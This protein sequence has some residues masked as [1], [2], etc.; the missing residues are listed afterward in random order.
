MEF[1]NNNNNNGHS[2][3]PENTRTLKDYINLVRNNL[4]PVLIIAIT[5]TAVSIIYAISAKNI[6]QSTTSLKISKPQGSLLSSAI[7]PDLGSFTDD[8]FISTEIEVMKSYS[9]RYNVAEALLDSLKAVNVPDKFYIIFNHS[10]SSNKIS[11]LSTR[12]IAKGLKSIVKIEQKRGIDIV[13]ISVE[14]PSAFEAAMIANIYANEYREFNLEINRDQL[15]VVRKFLAQQVND[16]QA[17]LQNTENL[18]SAFQAKNGIIALDAQS[19]ALITQLANFEAQRDDVVISLAGTNKVLKQLKDEL[20]QQDPKIA[21]Y[22]E[23]VA[24][25]SSLQAIQDGIAKLEVNKEIALANNSNIDKSVVVKD[26]DNQINALKS[27]LKQKVSIV[28]QG[29]FASSPDEIKDLTSKILDAEVQSRSLSIQVDELNKL[30]TKYESQF[31]K[32]PVT[33]IEYASLERNREAAEKL[34]ALLEEKYQEAVINEQSQPGN[35][36]IV[37]KGIIPTTPAKPNRILIVLIGL[38]L[39]LGL[40]FGYVFVKDYFDNTI[41]TPEDIQNRNINVLAWIPQIEGIGTNGNKEFEFIV[42][43]KPDSIPSEAFRALRTRIQYSKIGNDALKTI[44]VTSSVPQEGKTTVSVNI[45]GTFAQSNKKTLIIDTDL[46]KPRLHSIFK[47]QRYPG[48]IDYLFDQVK[49]EDIIRQSEVNNL[50]F[51][52]AGTIPPNPSEMLESKPMQDFLS[53]MRKRF[54]IVILDSAPIIAVTDSEILATLV[55]ATILVVSAEKTE[56]DLMVKASELIKKGASSFIGTVLNNFT[57]KSGYGS[58]YKYYYYYTS[59]TNGKKSRSSTK[60]KV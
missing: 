10:L 35:V 7:M 33:A 26:Y 55:D 58:Y 6:Y 53:E 54:D 13:D 14:S 18:L 40:S 21:A 39:G 27:Q 34:Y 32:L 41:K 29:I 50:S 30:V 25:Q 28:K 48:I 42:A 12:E 5:A 51:I 52:T 4:I 60:A 38:V 17:E 57:Y 8:R 16:K 45:A 49:L 20:N 1:N 11:L 23:S 37:D 9:I 46:R 15:T 56:I 24:Q 44:L 3:N 43:K 31:N 47:A 36:F 2:I 22:L 59:P 19:Q